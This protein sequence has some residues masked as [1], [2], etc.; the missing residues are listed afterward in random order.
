MRDLISGLT[1]IHSRGIAHENLTLRN[2]LIGDQNELKISDLKLGVKRRDDVGISIP[3]CLGNDI[4]CLGCLLYDIY[5]IRITIDG[6]KSLEEIERIID[7][8][9]L[10]FD[11]VSCEAIPEIEEL[12]KRML[13]KDEKKRIEM[14]EIDG[15][16]KNLLSQ[17]D[18]EEE[19][20]EEEEVEHHSLAYNFYLEDGFIREKTLKD[21]SEMDEEKFS[22]YWKNEYFKVYNNIYF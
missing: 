4:F 6:S 16:I 8:N 12:I 10:N 14:N 1:Y 13:E 5:S 2:L 11:R 7:K 18:N 3:N 21:I 15:I 19:E 9:D 20:E 17:F 22:E